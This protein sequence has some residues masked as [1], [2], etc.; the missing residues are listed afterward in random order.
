MCNSKKYLVILNRIIKIYVIPYSEF[1]A[2][3]SVALSYIALEI[4][5]PFH[6]IS[7]LHNSSTWSTTLHNANYKIKNSMKKNSHGMESSSE[8]KTNLAAAASLPTPGSL[9]PAR[10]QNRLLS[11]CLLRHVLRAAGLFYSQWRYDV[12]N[13]RSFATNAY[14]ASVVHFGNTHP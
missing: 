7:L 6:V 2:V 10:F 9:V 11:L 12:K 3:H 5:Y 1:D 14:K 13:Y 8:L 4:F